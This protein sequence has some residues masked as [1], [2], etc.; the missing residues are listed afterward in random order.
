MSRFAVSLDEICLVYKAYLNGCQH[1][2]MFHMF[3][4]APA[5][6]A[7]LPREGALAL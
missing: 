4:L 1:E 5:K 7:T 2:H 6:A 3:M